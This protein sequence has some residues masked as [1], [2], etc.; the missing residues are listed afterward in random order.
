LNGHLE[1]QQN[2]EFFIDQIELF[3]FHFFMQILRY[4]IEKLMTAFLKIPLHS[5]TQVIYELGKKSHS[6]FHYCSNFHFYYRY[7][8]PISQE[9][10]ILFSWTHENAALFAKVLRDI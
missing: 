7:V 5:E 8:T 2:I 6:G 1:Q 3:S 9:V 10:T 4:C